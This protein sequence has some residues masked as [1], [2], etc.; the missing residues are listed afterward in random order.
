M[1][2]VNTTRVNPKLE[3]ET[4]RPSLVVQKRLFIE[5]CRVYLHWPV[6][7]REYNIGTMSAQKIVFSILHYLY[8]IH[9]FY[10]HQRR[11]IVYISSYVILRVI[12]LC[13]SLPMNTKSFVL[14]AHILHIIM[15]FTYIIVKIQNSK[16]NSSCA[17]F[18]L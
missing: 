15:Y 18:I 13:Y 3:N 5:T 8:I 7:R 1:S 2:K 6:V 9:V 16:K 17:K 11:Q 12:L 4:R 10:M 14:H